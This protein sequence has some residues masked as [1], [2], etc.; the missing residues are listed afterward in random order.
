MA[1]LVLIEECQTKEHNYSSQH[2]PLRPIKLKVIDSTKANLIKYYTSTC[3]QLEKEKIAVCVRQINAFRQICYAVVFNDV[4]QL[5]FCSDTPVVH[6]F[7]SSSNPSKNLI[8]S[9]L[10]V[11]SRLYI[12][13]SLY[14]GHV[15]TLNLL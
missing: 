10:P 2:M 12:F 3:F 15:Y 9:H 7:R 6:S 5:G 1:A 8:F 4:S 14:R 13:F 11:S